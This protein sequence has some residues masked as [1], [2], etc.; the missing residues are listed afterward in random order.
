MSMPKAAMNEHDTIVPVQRE[1][2]LSGEVV[3][4]KSEAQ[5]GAMQES[6]NGK[7]WRGVLAPNGSHHPASRNAVHP[8]HD[9][10]PSK[11]PRRVELAETGIQAAYRNLLV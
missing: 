8:I 6:P 7:L 4:V 3:A 11:R 10:G 9:S 5:A 1:V 2:R